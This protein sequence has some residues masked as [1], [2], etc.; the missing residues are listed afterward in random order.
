[1]KLKQFKQVMAKPSRSEEESAAIEEALI[2]DDRV[3]VSMRKQ[4]T[5]Y[6]RVLESHAKGRYGEQLRGFEARVMRESIRVLAKWNKKLKKLSGK[7]MV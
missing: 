6:E 3:I 4:I 5:D 2:E 7:P 1:M